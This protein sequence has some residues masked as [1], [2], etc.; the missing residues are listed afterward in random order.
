S[1]RTTA[2]V[3]RGSAESNTAKA[4]EHGLSQVLL[5]QNQEIA[6]SYHYVGTPS[7]VIINPNGQIGSPVATGADAIR[8]LFT[9]TVDLPTVLTGPSGHARGNNGNGNGNSR[10]HSVAP[11][12]LAVGEPAPDISLP[13]LNGKI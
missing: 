5:Q 4:F 2:F 8:S 13:D 1:K 7:A 12:G 11:S 3:N 9:R 10:H 6:E